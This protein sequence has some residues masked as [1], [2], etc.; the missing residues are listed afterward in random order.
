MIE[1]SYVKRSKGADANGRVPVLRSALSGALLG[2]IIF[3]G[4]AHH[5]NP[6]Q[7]LTAGIAPFTDS[8]DQ[9]VRL[10][11]S[12]KHSLGAEDLNSLA[13]VYTAL[14]E[15]ANAYAHFLVESVSSTSF[16]TDQNN[17]RASD[18]MEAINTFNR[19]FARIG[20]SKQAASASPSP[21]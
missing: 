1:R 15:K 4:C 17:V 14:E 5:A 16:D 7:E 9:T 20:S 6:A 8:R 11:A 19:S 12:A 2:A 18:L 13:V 10:V 21:G 3:S